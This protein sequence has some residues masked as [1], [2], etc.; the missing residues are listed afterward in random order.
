MVTERKMVSDLYVFDLELF[1][2]EK[3]EPH[4]GDDLPS[5][6][7]FHSADSCKLVNQTIPHV[8]LMP[9]DQGIISSSSLV[10]WDKS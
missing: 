3:V 8:I 7:Y 10:E 5:A 4:P 6:R 9:T 2:W 1:N